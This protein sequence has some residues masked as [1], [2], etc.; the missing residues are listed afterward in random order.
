MAQNT[1]QHITALTIFLSLSLRTFDH[2]R[3]ITMRKMSRRT[4]SCGQDKATATSILA[5]A[6]P[7]NVQPSTLPAHAIGCRET[8]ATSCIDQRLF[9]KK[10][11]PKV[12][13]DH[14]DIDEQSFA[15]NLIATSN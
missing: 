12:Y 9:L 5:K 10:L 8:G 7:G 14:L 3:Q 4:R 13:I 1:T 6:L 15:F 2:I 11:L